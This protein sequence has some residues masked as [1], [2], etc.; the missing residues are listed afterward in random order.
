MGHIRIV[1]IILNFLVSRV[2]GSICTT[3]TLDIPDGPFEG[4][5]GRGLVVNEPDLLAKAGESEVGKSRVNGIGRDLM[6]LQEGECL[7]WRQR[8]THL[9]VWC[10]MGLAES[11][12]WARARAILWAIVAW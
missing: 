5:E 12:G 9:I 1:T 6:R 4:I 11:I 10:A 7:A 3:E 2:N 8:Q